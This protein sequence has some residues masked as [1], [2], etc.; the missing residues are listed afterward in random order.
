MARSERVHPGALHAGYA[1]A[2][3]LCLSAI[4]CRPAHLRRRAFRA[5]RG[6]AGAGK[7]RRRVPRRTA[8]QGTGAAGRRGDDAAGSFADVPYHPPL[9]AST[10]AETGA[11]FSVLR[12]TTDSQVADAIERLID[13]GSDRELNRINLLDFSARTGLD[14]ERVI[15]GF[16]HASRLV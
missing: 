14:E 16:L 4:R 6:C 13:K 15:S 10:M 1:A 7:D 12:Q 2:R 5:G 9:S 11:L 8:R 3:P